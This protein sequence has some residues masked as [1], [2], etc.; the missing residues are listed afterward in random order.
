MIYPKALPFPLLDYASY[1]VPTVKGDLHLLVHPDAASLGDRVSLMLEH[2]VAHE[3]IAHLHSVGPQLRAGFGRCHS[4]A[5]EFAYSLTTSLA[6]VGLKINSDNAGHW[7]WSVGCRAVTGNDNDL[8][9]WIEH[10]KDNAFV[11]VLMLG[12]PDDDHVGFLD[13]P[14][15]VVSPRRF[16]R[17][18]YQVKNLDAITFVTFAKWMR[19]FSR[20]PLF[21][22]HPEVST[23]AEE[24]RRSVRFHYKVTA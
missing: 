11:D 23:M 14:S 3:F 8:H 16:L 10:R 20:E 12:D 18:I 1:K 5:T 7:R 4:L 24:W 9:S 6:N 22:A 19:S 17:E 15:V 2:D 13:H 21:P